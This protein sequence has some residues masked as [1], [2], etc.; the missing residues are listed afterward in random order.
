MNL[1]FLFKQSSGRTFYGDYFMGKIA[2]IKYA[3]IILPIKS[4][5]GLFKGSIE[6]LS[7]CCN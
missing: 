5:I 2:A 7:S 3:H 6:M 1:L 4:L